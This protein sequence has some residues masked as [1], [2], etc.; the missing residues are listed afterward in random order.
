MA[1]LSIPRPLRLVFLWSAAF[2]LVLALRF[3]TDYRDRL[4]HLPSLV[5]E[6]GITASPEV[7]M[8]GLDSYQRAKRIR[9]FGFVSLGAGVLFCVGWLGTQS[10]R[11]E[12]HGA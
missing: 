5:D 9:R 2:T 12:P 11:K 6:H 7:A 1:K 10:Q 8:A 3:E 4:G